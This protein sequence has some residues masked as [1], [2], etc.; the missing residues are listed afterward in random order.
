MYGGFHVSHCHINNYGSMLA[1]VPC[2]VL[3]GTDGIKSEVKCLL[4]KSLLLTALQQAS[5]PGE[6]QITS[7]SSYPPI[8]AFTHQ[9]IDCFPQ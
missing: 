7:T 8:H 9:H 5:M 2:H 4:V 6:V 3:Q 1:R